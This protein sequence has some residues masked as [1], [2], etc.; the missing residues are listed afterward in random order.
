MKDKIVRA[1]HLALVGG[2]PEEFIR[3]SA[4][5]RTGQQTDALRTDP[6]TERQTYGKCVA[7]V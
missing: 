7:P 2:W 3:L 6:L 5:A 1:C 4:P